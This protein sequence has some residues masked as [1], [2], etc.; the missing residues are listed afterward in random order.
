M[1]WEVRELYQDRATLLKIVKN[2]LHLVASV[3]PY[4]SIWL[5]KAAMWSAVS[6]VLLNFSLGTRI[7][8]RTISIW[9]ASDRG[10]LSTSWSASCP[11]RIL[12]NCCNF[13]ITFSRFAF[14]AW[15][16]WSTWDFLFL[17]FV[18]EDLFVSLD[19]LVEEYLDFQD[20]E[21][22]WVFWESDCS[23]SIF[24]LCEYCPEAIG[25]CCEA[26]NSLYLLNS[27]AIVWY[28]FFRSRY[29]SYV[30]GCF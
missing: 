15:S 7:V 22:A 17:L 11:N 19:L 1:D 12:F 30:M 9:M 23:R 2:A 18:D 21:D 16:A 25:H 4:R 8:G 20:S 14:V 28:S 3:A 10:L 5:S 24:G 6:D 29:C 26:L 27:F 13:Y